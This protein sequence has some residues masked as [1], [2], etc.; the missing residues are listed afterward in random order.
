[1]QLH[2]NS[3]VQVSANPSNTVFHCK[4]LIGRQFDDTSVQ[5]GTKSWPFQVVKESGRAGNCMIRVQYKGETRTLVPEEIS[6]MLLAKM[7]ETAE[8]YLSQV[9]I[10]LVMSWWAFLSGEIPADALRSRNS[11]IWKVLMPFIFYYNYRY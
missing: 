2:R 3:H 4:R 6:A 7:K 11:G 10:V 1:M 8:A 9:S 5:S